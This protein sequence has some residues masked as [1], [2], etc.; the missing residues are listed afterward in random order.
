[1]ILPRS[2]FVIK[3]RGFS[4]FASLSE[5]LQLSRFIREFETNGHFVA[6]VDPLNLNRQIAHGKKLQISSLRK[7]SHGFTD[8]DLS[9]MFHTKDEP[10][11]CN[12]KGVPARL[13]EIIAELENKYAGYVGIEF[14]HMSSPRKLDW[15]RR[16]VILRKEF[17]PLPLE[18]QSQILMLLCRAQVFEEFCSTRFS[19]ATHFSLE[20]GESL[21][22][23]LEAILESACLSGV[24]AIEMGMAHRG[25]LNVLRNVLQIPLALLLD[26][27]ESYL[28]DDVGLPNNSDDVRYHLGASVERTFNNKSVRISLAAN[29]SHLEAVNGVVLGKA[30]ARQFLLSGGKQNF[31]NNPTTTPNEAARREVMPLLIHG[32]ASFF[33]GSVRESLGFSNLR[34]YTTGGTVHLIINNQIGFTTLP[35][36]AHSSTYCS[37]VAKSVDAPIFHVNADYPDE[38]VRICQSALKFR[39]EFLSDVVLNLWCYRRRGHNQSD[40]PEVSQPLMY[41][42]IKKHEPVSFKYATS[43][44]TD[45]ESYLKLARKEIEDAVKAQFGNLLLNRLP[46]SRAQSGE[47]SSEEDVR[48]TWNERQVL[49]DNVEEVVEVLDA[50]GGRDETKSGFQLDT[51]LE[52]GKAMFTLP[53]S[54]NVHPKVQAIFDKRLKSLSY[55]G[56]IRWDCAEQLAFGS[57]MVDGIDCRLSGQDVERGTFNQRH[58]VL[59]VIDEE[60]NQEIQY[61]PW[62]GLLSAKIQ[63]NRATSRR[64]GVLGVCNSPLSEESILAFE[65]GYSLYS[66]HSILGIW[67]AQFGDF[68]DCAQTIIDTFIASGEDKWVRQSGIVLLLPHGYEGQG[69]DHSSA[70]MERFLTL[71][72]EDDTPVNFENQTEF[73]CRQ[74]RQKVNMHILIPSTPAQYFHALRRHIISPFRKPLVIFSP[75]FLLHHGPCTS[76][77]Q[78]FGPENGRFKVIIGEQVSNNNNVQLKCWSRVVLCSGKLYYHLVE[79]R[80]RRNL[81]GK[82]ALIRVEQ[83]CPFP[84]KAVY[85]ELRSILSNAGENIYNIE[86][87]WAQEETKNRGAWTWI[88]PR[89]NWILSSLQINE[90][91]IKYI[92]RLTSAS[93]ATGSYTRHRREMQKLIDEV[94]N[95]SKYGFSQNNQE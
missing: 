68:S 40:A 5:H 47:L 12:F 94:L 82:I 77:L 3:K 21:I 76:N 46:L 72:N 74:A 53:K 83:L 89:M 50:F 58:A 23:G 49:K 35:K 34:D 14:S 95:L 57:L 11:L 88:Q 55:D 64:C 28:E 37:D 87:V 60:N 4:T 43:I 54:L 41:R 90:K 39:Q 81:S 61:H 20:G 42:E 1:M 59:N 2:L 85:E 71:A 70:F 31:I 79:E 15:V 6:A 19:A 22:P 75:K 62:T 27:F 25:R 73:D 52:I 18:K 7:E 69:P 13:E 17:Q 63:G 56:K 91:S 8:S 92:G 24:T 29:P 84:F 9:K 67:E 16:N 65:H 48:I 10:A 78:D 80:D 32:D 51:L 86:I 38:V 44:Q 45:P 30:R 36:Q 33:Q 66:S 26:R 93:P